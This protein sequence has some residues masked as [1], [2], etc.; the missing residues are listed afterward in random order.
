MNISISIYDHTVSVFSSPGGTSI[1][2][3]EYLILAETRQS[4]M[5]NQCVIDS[6]G[7]SIM[8]IVQ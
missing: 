4:I 6:T 1:A 5:C 2:L 8:K 7:H 3:S